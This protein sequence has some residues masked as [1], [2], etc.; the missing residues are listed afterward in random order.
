MLLTILIFIKSIL[1]FA[2][3]ILA[4]R[5]LSV[6]ILFMSTTCFSQVV[7]VETLR[8]ASDSLK[9]TGSASLDVSL[10]KNKNDIFRIANK[11]IEALNTYDTTE[12]CLH[13]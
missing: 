3:Q 13:L 11:E 9:W 12:K 10:I 8:K 2:N 6:L 4:M 5:Y 7:N 1:N